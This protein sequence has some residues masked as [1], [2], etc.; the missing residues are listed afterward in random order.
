MQII[1]HICFQRICTI[2]D[3]H[4]FS[5]QWDSLPMTQ[6]SKWS[7][8]VKRMQNMTA[9]YFIEC[10]ENDSFWLKHTM[11]YTIPTYLENDSH[12]LQCFRE[13]PFVFREN[14]K[15]AKSVLENAINE[16]NEC[17]TFIFRKICKWELVHK[18]FVRILK[19]Y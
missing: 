7:S 13:F 18:R 4:L 11:Q 2:I 14:K 19:F 9:I 17:V 3:S 5:G 8:F 16:S 6:F 15:W 1:I 12:F 10:N